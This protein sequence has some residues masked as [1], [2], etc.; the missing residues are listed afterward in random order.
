[1]LEVSPPTGRLVT[2][3]SHCVSIWFVNAAEGM[4]GCAGLRCVASHAWIILLMSHSKPPVRWWWGWLCPFLTTVRLLPESSIHSWIVSLRCGSHWQ[5]WVRTRIIL[6]ISLGRLRSLAMA[7]GR[8]MCPPFSISHC[9][10][11]PI[12]ISVVPSAHKLLPSK[13]FFEVILSGN[14]KNHRIIYLK[15]R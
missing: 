8:V 5:R 7:I 10:I 13:L 9:A 11:V 12:L 3:G 6:W 15:V 4:H 2:P 14:P 1:M